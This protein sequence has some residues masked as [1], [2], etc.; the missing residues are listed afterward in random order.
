MRRL[1]LLL[2]ASTLWIT[3]LATSPAMAAGGLH[4]S[5]RITPARVAIGKTATLIGTRL[6]AKTYFSLILSVPNT[7]R[8]PLET[9]IPTLA[10]SNAHGDLR[11]KFKMPVVSLCGPATVFV[12]ATRSSKAL[13]ATLTLTGCSRASAGAPPA[14]PAPP[15]KKKH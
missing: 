9:F 10:K 14:P 12:Y 7:A 15:K 5:V 4:G 2:I 13:K 6:P 3:A 11:V 1:V 8:S